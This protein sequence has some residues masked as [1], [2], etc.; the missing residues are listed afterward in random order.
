MFEKKEAQSTSEGQAFDRSKDI[1]YVTSEGVRRGQ[2]RRKED[3]VAG[4]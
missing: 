1:S 4:R 2:H 3:L